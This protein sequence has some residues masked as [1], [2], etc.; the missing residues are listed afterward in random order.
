M[1]LATSTAV[2]ALVCGVGRLGGQTPTSPQDSGTTRSQTRDERDQRPPWVTRRDA[3]RLV[4]A[5]LATIAVAPLD[6]PVA[7]ELD[8]PEWRDNAPVQRTADAIAVFGSGVPFMLSGVLYAAGSI[9]G[10]GGRL[11]EVSGA[12]L[13]NIEAI[14]LATVVTGLA[15]GLTGRALPDVPARHAFSF[16]RGFHDDN[17]PFVSFPSGHTAAAFAMAATVSGEVGRVN[18]NLA[19]VIT[20]LAF[21][22]ATG[23]GIARVVQRMHWTS[24][25]PLAAAIGTWSGN[26]VQSHAHRH[27]GASNVLRGLTV[28]PETRRQ[29]FI[30]WS[31]RAAAADQ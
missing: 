24:D 17:G 31:S 2:F 18:P 14:S 23:V 25:L 1:R 15:K 28:S 12:A 7:H 9:E 13:H 20:P 11:G 16:G 5:A 4:I 10:D 3:T 6:H 26:T 29:T 22:G 30:G 27:R 21:A 8:E 19:Q